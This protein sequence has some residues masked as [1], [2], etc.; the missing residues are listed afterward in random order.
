MVENHFAPDSASSD[1]SIQGIGKASFQVFP[2]SKHKV[3]YRLIRA[4]GEALIRTIGEE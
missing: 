4:I 2:L 1:S 3:D